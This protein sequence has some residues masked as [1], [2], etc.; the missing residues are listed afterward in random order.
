EGVVLTMFDARN[1]L[2]S[3]VEGDARENLGE[4]VFK[5]MIPR[6]VRVSEAPSYAMPVTEY[7]PMSKGSQAYKA[8]ANELIAKSV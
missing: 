7:D 3:Q 4:L 1:N 8:L 6:N 5:T 2:S